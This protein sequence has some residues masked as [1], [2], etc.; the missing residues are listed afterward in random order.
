MAKRGFI[1]N[2]LRKYLIRK[3]NSTRAEGNC[4]ADLGAKTASV[5]TTKTA[6]GNVGPPLTPTSLLP[7]EAP[8]YTPSE[9]QKSRVVGGIQKRNWW[10]LPDRRRWLPRAIAHNVLHILHENSY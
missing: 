8:T 1:S 4:R 9:V 2:W 10:E 6:L 3:G 5:E 7:G